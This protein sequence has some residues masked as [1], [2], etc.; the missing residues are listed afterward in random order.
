MG[1]V[2]DVRGDAAFAVPR[3]MDALDRRDVSYVFRLKRN[4][5][6]DRLAEPYLVR[7]VGRPPQHRRE[8]CHELSYQ[9]GGWNT[10]RRVVLVV[11]DDPADR[12]M[13]QQDLRYF[14]LVTTHDASRMPAEDLLDFYRQRGTM[15]TWIGEFKRD[16]SPRL[17]SPRL[18]E[19]QATFG[20][21]ALAYQL[22]HLARIF[23]DAV[24]KRDARSSIATFRL[25]LLKVAAVFIPRA[26]YIAMHTVALAHA[27]WVRTFGRLQRRLDRLTARPPNPTLSASG[28]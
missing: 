5:R 28:T 22:L 23:T 9:A 6:L 24:E 20:L 12:F 18:V 14:F 17:S 26:R 8:W 7:P 1:Q 4:P 19:N 15:E 16:V 25:R 27:I 3:F 11:V 2:V 10:A 13:G 21:F